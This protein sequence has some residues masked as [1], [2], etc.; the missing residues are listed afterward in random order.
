MLRSSRRP[1]LLVPAAIG[2]AAG[3]S[4]AALISAPRV[5]AVSPSDGASDVSALPSVSVTF[6]Q[7]MRPGTVEGRLIL[8]PPRA[9]TV[10]W[11]DRTMTFV[12]SQPWP[13]G[14]QVRVT[15]QGG[16]IST[17]G[18]PTF[19]ATT[20]SFT[21]GAGRL[22]YLWPA[23]GQA[24]L[25]AW[26]P[27]SAAPQ[28][29][30]EPPAGLIDFSLSQDGA[31]L[32]YSAYSETGTEIRQAALSGETDRLLQVCPAPAVCRSP[33][34]SSDGVLAYLQEE[35]Q[36]DRS[37]LRRVWAKAID[38]GE[39]YTVA[40]ADHTTTQPAWSSQDWLVV[41][42]EALGGYAFYDRVDASQSRLAFA[43]PNELGE[44]P[45]WSPD[46]E[47]L[48]FAEMLFLPE[49]EAV[50]DPEAPPQYYSHLKQVSI[51]DGRQVD[52]SGE[53]AF[54]VEDSGPAF[55]PDGAWIA[56]SRRSLD[57]EAWT[58]GRQLWTMRA[59]G[60]EPTPLTDQPALNHAGIDW[61]PDGS[62]LAYIL[63]DQAR[64]DDPPEIWWMW[65][66]GRAGD[67]IVVGGYEPEWIP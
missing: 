10:L 12:P 58:L 43:V 25:Y 42:D 62:R 5:T 59:D 3:L 67:R 49:V 16:A 39:A 27:T 2:L 45:A 29:L 8:T 47:T 11:S 56:F 50:G 17:R 31:S 60:T 13:E 6:S 46:G 64:A 63:F 9:G 54:L 32:I 40:P 33:G 38:G 4:L 30:L 15:L 14:E 48:V 28:S 21:V 44:K 66:D 20:W 57:P 1:S 55:S 53:Q 26:S 41:Y 35:P 65:S 34:L 23:G 19:A 7:T 61:S 52:L 18:L 51:D 24:G 36:A 37:M 22:G